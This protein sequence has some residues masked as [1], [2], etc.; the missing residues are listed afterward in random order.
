MRGPG[1]WGFREYRLEASKISLSLEQVLLRFRPLRRVSR[2]MAEQSDYT[3]NFEAKQIPVWFLDT[4]GTTAYHLYPDCGHIN[5]HSEYALSKSLVEWQSSDF[6]YFT[7]WVEQIKGNRH[8]C[9]HCVSQFKRDWHQT[10][11]WSS[12]VE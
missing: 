10:I 4:E 11:D 12:L 3:P 8:M 1:V 9:K 5:Q 7:D 6:E 2:N